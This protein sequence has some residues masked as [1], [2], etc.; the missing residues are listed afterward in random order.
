MMPVFLAA[1]GGVLINIV[2]TIVGRVMIALGI[3]V[4]TY[5]GVGA[6]ID[7]LKAQAISNFNSLPS[8]VYSILAMLKVGSA[9]NIIVSAIMARLVLDGVTSDTFKRWVIR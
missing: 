1:L 5:T 7:F 4:V 9:I 2:G 8:E 6:S 3:G